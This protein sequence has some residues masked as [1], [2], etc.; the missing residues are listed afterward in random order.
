MTHSYTRRWNNVTLKPLA[1]H[2]IELLRNWRNDSTE[3]L[4]IT[5][6][7]FITKEMQSQWFS[8]YLEDNNCVM[9][10]A[11]HG[12]DLVGSV[13]LYDFNGNTA[14]FGKLMIGNLYRGK[15]FG[16]DITKA[17]LD[18]GFED[19]GL[20]NIIASVHTENLPALKI[21]VKIGFV[22]TGRV[23]FSGGAEG[24]EFLLALPKERY[25]RLR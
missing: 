5:R 4:Y 24:F 20:T 18:I 3:N 8:R 11:Y 23:P 16:H 1:Q 21:Y 14:E 7:P 13:S 9:M 25:K 10:A 2:E 6:M 12:Q 17:C 22:I 15:G 19:M